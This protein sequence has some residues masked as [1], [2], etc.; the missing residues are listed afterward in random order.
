M[1]REEAIRRAVDA[2]DAK[3]GPLSGNRVVARIV[4]DSCGLLDEPTG[5]FTPSLSPR[6]TEPVQT[7][8]AL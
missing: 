1:S 4:V 8:G 5:L 3:F 6:R 2:L 7:T